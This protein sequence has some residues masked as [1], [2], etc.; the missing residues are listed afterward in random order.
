[1]VILAIN[2]PPLF[3]FLIGTLLLLFLILAHYHLFL[4]FKVGML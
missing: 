1:M 3:S 2:R 4:F